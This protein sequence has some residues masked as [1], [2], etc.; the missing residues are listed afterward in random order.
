MIKF[1]YQTS[2]IDPKKRIFRGKIEKK[3]KSFENITLKASIDI[4]C[5]EVGCIKIITAGQYV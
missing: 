4:K 5:Y 1:F 3:K 2:K